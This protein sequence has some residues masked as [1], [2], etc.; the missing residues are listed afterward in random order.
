MIL[1]CFCDNKRL[2]PE[3][4]KCAHKMFQIDRS[5]EKARRNDSMIGNGNEPRFQAE[6]RGGAVQVPVSLDFI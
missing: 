1:A 3:H 6:N 4:S 2:G 5:W